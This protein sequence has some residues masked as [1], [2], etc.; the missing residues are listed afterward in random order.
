[1]GAAHR[2]RLDVAVQ[3][4]MHHGT[5]SLPGKES[6]PHRSGGGYV[7]HFN[8]VLR[9]SPEPEVTFP[10]DGMALVDGSYHFFI[11]LMMEA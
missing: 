1:M 7:L 5:G 10:L 9:A 11:A 3:V 4:N 8:S 2:E 6:S